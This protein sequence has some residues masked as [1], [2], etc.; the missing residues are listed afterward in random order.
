M[1]GTV[2]I[3]V[4]WINDDEGESAR[5]RRG[6]ESSNAG[7]VVEVEPCLPSDLAN[8][9]REDWDIF[10][11]D[12]VLSKPATPSGEGYPDEGL[13]AAGRIREKVQDRPI[14][15]V[16]GWVSSDTPVPDLFDFIIFTPDLLRDGRK[17]LRQDGLDYQQ[18]RRA[19]KGTFSSVASLLAAPEESC[20]ALRQMLPPTMREGFPCRNSEVKK[21]AAP[22]VL[23]PVLAFSRWVRY[24]LLAY[25]GPLLDDLRAATLLGVDEGYFG[26]K[27]SQREEIADAVYSGVF[28]GSQNRWWR[29]LLCKAAFSAEKAQ[30]MASARPSEVAPEVFGVPQEHRSE[31]AVCGAGLPE[32]VASDEDDVEVV[33]PVHVSCSRPD[34]TR[35]APSLFDELR[36]FESRTN[37]KNTGA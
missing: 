15:L 28:A 6:L 21:E 37:G 30:A 13:A 24:Q 25:G 8:M 2:M 22:L 26:S 31:C 16:S 18:V 34:P 11:V 5:A 27:L 32:T 23:S 12:F 33:R 36:L 35:D 10:L 9:L 29:S 17:L 19:Q 3:R 14:Y 7:A 4:L 20:D 1:S